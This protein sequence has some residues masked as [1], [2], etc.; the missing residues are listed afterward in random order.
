MKNHA[1]TNIMESTE[2]AAGR[3]C[4]VHGEALKLVCLEE[5][6]HYMGLL[7]AD[8][9]TSGPQIDSFGTGFRHGALDEVM[10]Q[11]RTLLGRRMQALH[12]LA[13]LLDA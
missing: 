9:L 4:P 10:G 3:R 6:R 13:H 1:Y 12:R 2:G 7:C 8:C 11:K 5:G